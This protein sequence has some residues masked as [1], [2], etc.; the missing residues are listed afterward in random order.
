MRD[1]HDVGAGH[2]F[3]QLGRHVIGRAGAGRRVVELAG[4]RLGERD[5]LLEVLHAERRD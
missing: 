5:E 1:M 4:L 3:E 2:G